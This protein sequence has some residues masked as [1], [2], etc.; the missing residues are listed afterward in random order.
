MTVEKSIYTFL[1]EVKPLNILLIEE[2]LASQFVIAKSLDNLGDKLDITS[3]YEEA[4]KRVKVYDYDLILVDLNLPI[5]NG[6]EL[7][8]SIR[9]TC[10]KNG[11]NPRIIGLTGLDHPSLST[12]ISYSHV[13]DYVVRSIDYGDLKSKIVNLCYLQLN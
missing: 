6:F 8:K 13:D 4:I 12:L 11:S 2:D 3:S 5:V 9:A 1:E 10:E 7:S